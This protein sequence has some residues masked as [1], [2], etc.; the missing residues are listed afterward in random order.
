MEASP[1]AILGKHS[2]PI[3]SHYRDALSPHQRSSSLASRSLPSLHK[4]STRMGRCLL[5]PSFVAC[6]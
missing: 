5:P 1:A 4:V 3:L 2:E 6:S